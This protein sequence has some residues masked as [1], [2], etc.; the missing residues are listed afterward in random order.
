M[1]HRYLFALICF[2]TTGAVAQ[3]AQTWRLSERPI[4]SIGSQDGSGPDVF[5]AIVGAVRLSSGMF[6]VADRM[7][8]QLRVF[9]PEGKHLK[10]SGGSGG[11]PGEFRTMLPIQRCAGD[12]M[13]VYDPG[14]F[15]ISVFDPG[16]DF[17][18]TLDARKWAP[19]GAP[20]FDFSCHSSG[21]LLFIHRSTEP[22]KGIGVMRPNVE[23]T[24]VDRYGTVVSLGQFPASERHFDGHQAGP[25]WLGK[26]T[27]AAVG[28][29]SVFVGTGD[30]FE[31]S[32]FSLTGARSRTLRD[33]RA[34][35]PITAADVDKY[36]EER[37]A[38]YQDEA[39]ASEAERQLRAVEFPK[40]FPAYGRIVVDD[41][42]N[43]WIDG[44]PLPGRE[45]RSCTVFTMSGAKQAV[46]ELPNRFRLL[47]AGSDWVLGVWRDELDVNYLRVYRLIK[48]P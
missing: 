28:S 12:T 7:N 31:V 16:G 10:T 32:E 45:S 39:R 38:R 36:I 17:V 34:P 6:V 18:R 20:P 23:I 47:Q 21:T 46:L 11:G 2:A 27:V 15:R 24:L 33:N 19:N 3:Q 13:F 40:V 48:R 41:L 43:P 4:I 37:V 44:Y 9:S 26:E 5:G 35:V 42:G 29:N 8:L 30:S 14:L 25:R 22:P 1:T